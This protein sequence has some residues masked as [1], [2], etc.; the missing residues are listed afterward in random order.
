MQVIIEKLT[1]VVLKIYA[2]K[3]RVSIL[4][5]YDETVSNKMVVITAQ[6]L[7]NKIC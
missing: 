6:K 5:D 1:V 3:T 2:H 7:P 4:M